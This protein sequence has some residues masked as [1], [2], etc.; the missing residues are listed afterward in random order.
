MNPWIG[1]TAFLLGLVVFVAIRVP[2]D[3]RSKETK[4]AES[5]KG[6]VEVTLLALMGMGGFVLP[7]VFILSS[8]F[9]FAD[10]ALRLLPLLG[11]IMCLGFS[12][13]L[14]HLRRFR[15]VTHLYLAEVIQGRNSIGRGRDI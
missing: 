7:L 14:F 8:L 6:A 3:K 9:S 13:W 1:K 12:F 4:I 15:R 11:G 2:H 5:H 10:Y